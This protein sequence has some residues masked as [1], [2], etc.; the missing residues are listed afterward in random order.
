MTLTA[1]YHLQIYRLHYSFRIRIYLKLPVLEKK[2]KEKGSD[3]E[4]N[5][6]RIFL[7]LAGQEPISIIYIY[8]F[9]GNICEAMDKEKK[10][11]DELAGKIQSHRHQ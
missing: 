1:L 4:L 8:I 11:K 7:C 10:N 9:T 5:A 6:H 3:I 2:E